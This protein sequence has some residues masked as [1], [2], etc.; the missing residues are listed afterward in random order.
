MNKFLSTLVLIVLFGSGKSLFSQ[1]KPLIDVP[2]YPV[3]FELNSGESFTVKRQWKGNS[4][5][6]QV[7][8]ISIEP[9]YEPSYWFG[10]SLTRLYSAVKVNVNVDGQPYTLIH[11]PYQMPQEIGGLR[12]YVEA[13]KDW[14]DQGRFDLLEI[15]KEV[16]F[17]ATAIGESWGPNNMV[18]PIRNY[19]WRSSAYNN[20]WSSLVPYNQLYFH[21]GE[22]RGAI[23]DKLDVVSPV[24]GVI[25]ASP[26]PDGDG[27]SNAV[28]IMNREG[29]IYRI[30]H[31][32]IEYIN[33]EF[34]RLSP[35]EKGALLGRTGETWAGG[36]NQ[37]IDP[38]CHMEISYFAPFRTI[39]MASFPYLME[40][41]MRDYPDRV[42]AVAGGYQFT[43]PEKEITLDASR[44]IAREGQSIASYQW[45]L[46]DGRQVDDV[47]AKIRYTKPGLYTEELLVK[48][49]SGAT[50]RDF[51]QVRVWDVDHPKPVAMGWVFYYPVRDVKAGTP[52]LFWERLRNTKTP[53]KIDFGDGDRSVIEK[54]LYHTYKKPG[55]YAVTFSATGPREEPITEKLE[56][57][58]D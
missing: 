26:L 21:R 22:D 7:K 49:R 34:P 43:V 25:I 47:F 35:V 12:L 4:I 46:S 53:I 3:M 19:R 15:G 33:K 55:R 30:S 58:I 52:V 11:R 23:P 9:S 10:D 54:E 14:N 45:K 48:T 20:T 27:A 50:D 29:F 6:G 57:V 2:D 39:R 37:V 38:H 44:S 8:L 28:K 40:A 13:I 24:D 51:I 18:Y 42:L 41:Y 17:S 1:S 56:V 31:M 5:S 32:N 16:R 36:K